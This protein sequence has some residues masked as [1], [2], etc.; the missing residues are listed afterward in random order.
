MAVRVR[1]I[2]PYQARPTCSLGADRSKQ[3]GRIDLEGTCRIGSD[4]GG[5]GQS[6]DRRSI[7]EKKPANLPIRRRGGLRQN[8]VDH[9]P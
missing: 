4:I 6:F 2:M 5:G 3:R 7:A 9:C 8:V 1:M